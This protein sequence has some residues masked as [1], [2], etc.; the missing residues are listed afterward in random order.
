MYIMRLNFE[1]E[2]FKVCLFSRVFRLIVSG[3]LLL[4]LGFFGYFMYVWWILWEKLVSDFS[5]SR[6]EKNIFVI[7]L[8]YFIV[9]V[10]IE[11]VFCSLVL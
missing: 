2:D 4:Y 5:V 7:K 9:L 3:C 6:V 1:L 11:I 10:R 8:V